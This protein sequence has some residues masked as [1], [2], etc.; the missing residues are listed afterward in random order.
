MPTKKLIKRTRADHLRSIFNNKEEF[1]EVL[2]TIIKDAVNEAIMGFKKRCSGFDKKI[3]ALEAELAKQ[4]TW[5]EKL[6]SELKR[7]PTQINAT[8]YDYEAKERK[9]SIVAMNIPEFGSKYDHQNNKKDIEKV[10]QLL[11]NM[12]IGF[13]PMAVY[14]MG[15][16]R[17]DGKPRLVKIVFP[18]SKSQADTLLRAHR[19]RSFPT[20]QNPPVYL[21]PSMT[22][23]ERETFRQERMQHRQT[24]VRSQ[25]TPHIMDHDNSDS[26]K[27]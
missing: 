7:S 21:R 12:D 14:C 1:M 22:R 23:K 19:L 27:N 6:E 8:N 4:R 3:E 9:R 18:C 15:R 11:R 2:K 25:D 24:T 26:S 16:K 20:G 17:E 13:Q 5:M 10:D